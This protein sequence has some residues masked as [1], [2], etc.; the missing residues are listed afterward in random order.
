VT[1]QLIRASDGSHLWSRTYDRNLN[2]IFKVQDDIAGTV[3]RELKV[4]LEE[5][6]AR[7]QAPESNT[8]AYNLFLQAQYFAERNTR[9]GSEKAVELYQAATRVDPGYA[10]AWARLANTSLHQASIGW[11][12]AAGGVARARDALQRALRIDPGFA[13]AHRV[14]GNLFE[15]FDWNWERAAAEYQRALELDPNDLHARI[16]LADL[17]AVR[18]G[19]FDERI[20]YSRQALAR[21]PLDT[22]ELWSAGWML[23]SAGR[24]E[25]SEATLRKLVELNPTFA[26]GPTFLGLTLL[27]RKRYAEALAAVEKETDESFKLSALPAVYWAL[28]RRAQSDAALRELETKYAAGS[29][30]NIAEMHAWRGEVDAAFRW[31]DRAY[32]QRDPGI[33]MVKIDPLLRDLRGQPG[34]R[35]L[36]GR[37]NLT[38]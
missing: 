23:M 35:S 14:Q 5:A 19:Q 24:L 27:L 33:E 9:A 1:A 30:F 29:A 31:L 8:D 15:E 37:M 32:R 21:D 16:A 25:E 22:N 11:V 2:D 26:G 36:L 28:G 12:A 4:A 17:K 6:D 13:Y 18:F 38:D 20:A 10:L 34:Y 3:A 7:S